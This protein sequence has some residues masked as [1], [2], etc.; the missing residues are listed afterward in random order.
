MI[1]EEGGETPF[2]EKWASSRYAKLVGREL[3]SLSKRR[4]LFLKDLTG[5]RTTGVATSPKGKIVLIGTRESG[6]LFR[7]EDG[8]LTQRETLDLSDTYNC[9]GAAPSGIAW[10]R[11]RSD[12]V[13]TVAFELDTW[14]GE[15]YR[16]ND[17]G[18]GWGSVYGPLSGEVPRAVEMTEYNTYLARDKAFMGTRQED[19]TDQGRIFRSPNNGNDWNQVYTI[20]ERA[21]NDLLVGIHSK[22]YACGA[23][24]SADA[25]V[26]YGGVYKSGDVGDSWEKV[27]DLTPKDQRALGIVQ[28]PKNGW[29]LVSTGAPHESG[30]DEELKFGETNIYRS[31]DYGDSWEVVYEA[32]A[33]FHGLGMDP[34]SGRVYV[35]LEDYGMVLESPNF[36]D[37]WRPILT[38]EQN[39]LPEIGFSRNLMLLSGSN[40][41]FMTKV[42]LS[43]KLKLFDKAHFVGTDGT[44]WN[45]ASISA[46]DE[47]DPVM[48]EKYAR[49]TVYFL[50]DTAGTLTI[51]IV[52]PDGERKT[53]GTTSV[54]ADTLETYTISGVAG[55][56][57]LKFDSNATVTAWYEVQG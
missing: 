8:G 42:I 47:T 1:K 55:K 20:E 28:H 19:P 40:P 13:L 43:D 41:D 17:M 22:V 23:G 48:M 16:S 18:K 45:D 33:D 12:I 15:V 31:R 51:Q 57:A 9:V 30:V 49:K 38:T 29:L 39:Y 44:T 37:S 3:R 11:G 25:S 50:S 26:A 21:V 35:G 14:S 27:L 52:D 53:Y 4:G 2:L 32:D 34:H 56:V 5:Y 6:V 36:G 54:D 7:S 46:G 24:L 10:H